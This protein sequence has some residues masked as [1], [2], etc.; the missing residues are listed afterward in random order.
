[1]AEPTNIFDELVK[2]LM[3]NYSKFAMNAERALGRLLG[4]L[5]RVVVRGFRRRVA[6]R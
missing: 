1:M 3:I 4:A 5:S 6:R 2:L